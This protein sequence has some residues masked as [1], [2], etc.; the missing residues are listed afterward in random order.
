MEKTYI[1]ITIGPIYDTIEKMSKPASLWGGSYLFSY[2]AREICGELI[3]SGI[4]KDKF[5][6]PYFS[7]ELLDSVQEYIESG[8]GFYH[9]R[10]III[11]DDLDL[12]KQVI[13]KVK[14]KVVEKFSKEEYQKRL[15]IYAEK[16]GIYKN[17][18]NYEN[19]KKYFMNYLQIYAVKKEIDENENVIGIISPLLDAM[20]L[21]KTF[22][23]S[24]VNNFFES[25]FEN[26]N[27][28]SNF[29]VKDLKCWQ[30]FENGDNIKTTESIAFRS[31]DGTIKQASKWSKYFAVVQS[32]G[33]NMGS[34]L[35]KLTIKEMQE[36][37]Q[38]C[39]EYMKEACKLIKQFGGIT[40]YA[41]GDDLLFLTPVEN[42][43]EK[44]NRKNKNILEL[45]KDISKSFGGVFGGGSVSFGISV[46]HYKSP[47]YE[48][49][50]KSY[51]LLKEAKYGNK[52][53]VV[54]HLQKR[55]G[56]ST[57]LKIKEFNKNCITDK[58][59]DLVRR[60]ESE[61]FLKS[62]MRN[63]AENKILFSEALKNNNLNNLFANILSDDEDKKNSKEY[64]NLISEIIEYLRNAHKKL[65]KNKDDN[66]IEVIDEISSILKFV[67]FYTEKGDE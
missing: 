59:S 34:K 27:I 2:I 16:K 13:S 22:V 1:G 48:A 60:C 23:S 42:Y 7:Q 31:Y 5:I 4:E 57:K 28:K 65:D 46:Q 41:G 35:K 36:Y 33:D 6:V 25:F 24:E 52:N 39:L 12:I 58:I 30:L 17:E 43:N 38:N 20:E 51:E 53:T 56:Q 29:L 45:L 49:Y 9:D 32:D 19:L 3:N 21:Q 11:C 18:Y 50:T 55:S 14:C 66:V 8:V 40:I 54:L 67:K 37:S 62:V 47:L 63:I 26:E 15:R 44:S 61:D 10:I 64:I